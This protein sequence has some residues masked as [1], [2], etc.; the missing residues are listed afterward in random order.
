M[1]QFIFFGRTIN[2]ASC[3]SSRTQHVN[4]RVHERRAG[5]GASL[6]M[7]AVAASVI[8]DLL[9]YLAGKTFGYRVLAGLC[10][11]SINPETCVTDQ[12]RSSAALSLVLTA[13]R[14]ELPIDASELLTTF[15]RAGDW[16]EPVPELGALFLETRGSLAAS[17]DFLSRIPGAEERLFPGYGRFESSVDE[18]VRSERR[19]L[20]G[21]L[22]REKMRE[23]ETE[24]REGERNPLA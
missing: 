12:D 5:H 13:Q 24:R 20:R 15:H 8:A 9:W 10:R 16:L 19:T 14:Y 2:F 11:T 1:R 3:A 23:L 22:E 7:V 6:L 21:P 4:R 18:R 17:F